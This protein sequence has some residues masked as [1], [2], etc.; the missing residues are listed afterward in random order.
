M[1]TLT[2]RDA[3]KYKFGKV[4]GG[5]ASGI[6]KLVWDDSMK[7]FFVCKSIYKLILQDIIKWQVQLLLSSH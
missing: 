4:I 1:E 5:G 3:Q 6:V 2:P 7:E